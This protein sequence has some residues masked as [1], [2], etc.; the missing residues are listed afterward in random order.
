ML[1]AICEA[2]VAGNKNCLI[3]WYMTASFAYY[4]MDRP[5]ITDGL[6]DDLCLRMLCEWSNLEHFHKHLIRL[7]DLMAGSCLLGREEFP[8]RVVGA[9][10]YL[11]TAKEETS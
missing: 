4:W 8:G 11:L 10:E 7:D 3:P 9:T 1:D 6:Y 2:D 5:L